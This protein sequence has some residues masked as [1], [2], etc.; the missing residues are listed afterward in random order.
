[1][2]FRSDA[3]AAGGTLINNR[4]KSAEVTM[5]GGRRTGAGR[6]PGAKNKITRELKDVILGAL[7][8][9]GGQEYLARQAAEN[10][11]AFLALLG[12]LLPHTIAGTGHDGPLVVQIVRFADDPNERA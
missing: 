8:A 12:K 11:G 7:N 10:P 1:M 5:K 2:S 4:A 9:A 3:P 6:P